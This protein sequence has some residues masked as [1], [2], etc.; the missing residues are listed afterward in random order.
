MVMNMKLQIVY[1]D[2]TKT[3]KDNPEYRES[4]TRATEAAD[5]GDGVGIVVAKFVVSTVGD[6]V[7]KVVL[8]IEDEIVGLVGSVDVTIVEPSEVGIDVGHGVGITRAFKA[9]WYDVSG[10]LHLQETFV[11]SCK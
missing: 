10:F 4:D 5:I 3:M 9:M 11:A 1:S 7:E 2:I 8:G 6:R